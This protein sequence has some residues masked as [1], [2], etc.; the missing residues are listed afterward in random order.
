MLVLKCAAVSDDE[1]EQD[2][3]VFHSIPPL[4]LEGKLEMQWNIKEFLPTAPYDCQQIFE[5]II[6][7]VSM[8]FRR[9]LPAVDSCLV[10][11]AAARPSDPH[12]AG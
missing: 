3:P 6:A 1:S 2:E 12:G 7:D 9:F 10:L 11:S 5:L 4:S 8:L